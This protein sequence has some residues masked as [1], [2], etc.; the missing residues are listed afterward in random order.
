MFQRGDMKR[1]PANPP[2][3]RAGHNR[4]CFDV[5]DDGAPGR[6][7]TALADVD[8]LDLRTYQQLTMAR[9]STVIGATIS[10]I[11]ASR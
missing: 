11:D 6:D 9:A 3:R 1:L 5:M 7:D 8:P 10:G 4:S 2:G